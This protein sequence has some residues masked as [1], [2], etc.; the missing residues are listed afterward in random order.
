MKGFLKILIAFLPLLLL[1]LGDAPQVSAQ[2]IFWSQPAKISQGTNYALQPVITSDSKGYVHSVWMETVGE[3]GWWDPPSLPTPGIFYSFWNGD[4]WSTPQQVN[5]PAQG[6]AELPS[7]AVTPNDNLHA[8]WDENASGENQTFRQVYYS[9]YNG[10]SWS[11]PVSLSAS[12][13]RTSSSWEWAPKITSDSA[14][15]LYVLFSYSD[16]TVPG[17]KADLLYTKYTAAG[18]TWSTP[19]DISQGSSPQFPDLVVDTSGNVHVL[20]WDTGGYKRG[21][22][23]YTVYNGSSWSSI[24]KISVAQGESD[25][26]MFPH[27]VLDSGGNLH[28]AWYEYNIS[29]G[30]AQVDYIRKPSGLNWSSLSTVSTTVAATY[31][32]IPLIGLTVDN[33]NN[34]YVGWGQ[35]NTTW[36]ADIYSYGVDAMYRQY[37]PSTS[38]WSNPNLIHSSKYFDAPTIWRD[39][40]WNQHFVWS[41]MNPTSGQ[42]EFWYSEVPANVGSYS[43]SSALTITTAVTDDTLK[44][45]ANALATTATI[46]AQVGPVPASR[47]T[48]VTTI[49]RSY[50]FRPSPTTFINGKVAIAT[51]KYTDAEILGTNESQMKAYIWDATL[52]SGLGG[53]SSSFT[54]SV[55]VNTNRISVDLAHFSLYG[56][57]GSKAD[58]TVN[59]DWKPPISN[60]E[61]YAMVD[62]STLPIKFSLNY[63]NGAPVPAPTKPEDVKVYIRKIVNGEINDTLSLIYQFGT[64]NDNIRYDTGSNQYLVNLHTRELNLDPGLYSIKVLYQDFTWGTK[65][66]QLTEPGKVKGASTP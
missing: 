20:I 66:F 21:G 40:W 11:T 27:L 46:S 14:G 63:D 45:P 15:N 10:S 8:V 12:V 41:E 60:P 3:N 18:G 13:H 29:T 57:M 16:D 47:D 50:T 42:W 36:Y 39:K 19:V 56:I 37:N 52:N 59:I 65:D 53:W 9:R 28:G 22:I 25:W 2:D 6:A 61:L 1:I 7:I 51:I 62:G 32:W 58:K 48:N 44:I 23:Y 38:T 55:N 54:T 31:W 33:N 30:Q 4:T 26:S 43:P 24:Q 35:Y 49:P 17:R 34:A 64:G 5:S